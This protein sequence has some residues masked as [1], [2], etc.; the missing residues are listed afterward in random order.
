MLDRHNAT[1][2]LW[3]GA[4]A[5]NARIAEAWTQIAGAW[6]EIEA[7]NRRL[8]DEWT[9][10]ER[11][12]RARNIPT[13]DPTPRGRLYGFICGGLISLALWIIAAAWLAQ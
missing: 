11:E 13:F 5:E 10:I 9:A 7:S 8:A 6:S 4:Y 12:A 2:R 1:V 3:A